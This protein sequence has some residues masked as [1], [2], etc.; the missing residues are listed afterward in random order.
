MANSNCHIILRQIL[1]FTLPKTVDAFQ[2][3]KEIG[4]LSQKKLQPALEKLFDKYAGA[5]E[6]IQI[7]RLDIDIGAQRWLPSGDAFVEVIVKAVEEQ[8]NAT[9]RGDK[10]E[11]KRKSSQQTLFEEWTYFLEYGYLPHNAAKNTPAYFQSVIPEILEKD[12]SYKVHLINSFKVQPRK[13]DRLVKQYPESFLVKLFEGLTKNSN[14]HITGFKREMQRLIKV[15][16]SS[17]KGGISP[18][19]PISQKIFWRWVFGNLKTDVNIRFDEGAVITAYIEN[20]ISI[21]KSS[22]KGGES[23][24]R[25]T[26]SDILQESPGS[27]P[28]LSK[29]RDNIAAKVAPDN[30]RLLH[31]EIGN[32]RSHE[33]L[34]VSKEKPGP[35]KDKEFPPP[36]EDEAKDQNKKGKADTSEGSRRKES[37]ITAKPPDKGD[38][39]QKK[40]GKKEIP[41]DSAQTSLAKPENERIGDHQG[42]PATEDREFLPIDTGMEHPEGSFWY[43]SHAGIVLLHTFLPVYFNKCGLIDNREFIDNTARERAVQLLLYLATGETE[44]PENDLLLPKFLCGVPFEQPINGEII[45]SELEK[46]ESIHLLKAVIAHWGKL[47]KT[48]PDGLREGFLQRDGK[49]EKRPQGWYLSV[50]QK[51]IDIL[52]D[53]LPWN[54]RIIK[55]SWMGEILRVE[56]G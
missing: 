46:A 37:E 38:P 4:E 30:K 53:F 32:S 36:A 5:D 20:W 34:P 43:I 25:Q 42:T 44:T 6:V 41:E 27:F 19:S 24:L 8:L 13:V 22:F 1:D 12:A 39:S 14:S 54:L 15:A 52:L 48:S 56:W 9:I 50:E 31:K 18:F 45:L 55:L 47:K 21:Q 49:L 23:S 40:R 51:N 7:D 11:I 2:L 29:L 26:L 28:L 10:G 17:N 33:D 35:Q 3:Q 16:I